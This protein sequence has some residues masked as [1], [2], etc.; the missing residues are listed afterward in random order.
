[1]FCLV[2]LVLG[3]SLALCSVWINRKTRRDL[4]QMKA[5]ELRTKENDDRLHAFILENPQD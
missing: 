5:I 2:I 3:V 1:M 4:L